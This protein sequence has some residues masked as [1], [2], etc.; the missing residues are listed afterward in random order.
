MLFFE[1]LNKDEK[2]IAVEKGVHAQDET[3]CVGLIPAAGKGMRAYPSTAKRPKP[4]FEF[5]PLS[6]IER[7]IEMMRDKVG[8]TTIYIIVGY[9][10]EMILQKLGTGER[11]GVTIRYILCEDVD[12]GLARGI[13]LAK[14]Y[15]SSPFMTILGDEL[16]MNTNH[17]KL[18]G[19]L[20][21]DCDVV[22][23]VKITNNRELIRQNY[24]VSLDEKGNITQLIEKPSHPKNNFLGCGTFIFK[25]SIF[26]Y[27]ERTFPSPATDRIELIDV[28]NLMAKDGLRVSAFEITGAYH[29]INR[30]HDIQ[31]ALKTYRKE[32]FK[33]QTVSLVIPA[34]N[35][36]D[37]IGYV[38]DN[39]LRANVAVDEIVVADN[40]ST[41]KTAEIARKK[42]A[43]VLS[44]PLSGYGDALKYGMDN[45]IGDILILSEADGS[46]DAS[47]IPKILEYLKDVDMV[48]GSRTTKEMIEQGANMKCILRWGNI[49]VA[50][51][52]QLLWIYDEPR[53]TDVGCT[54]RGI[55]RETYLEI[56]DNLTSVGPAFSPEMMVELLRARRKI[57]EI[58]V[59]YKARIGGESKH[60]GNFLHIMRTGLSMVAVILKKRFACL[61]GGCG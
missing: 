13:L 52:M 3:L 55:W 32:K 49:F 20:M 16:Y 30:V 50:K 61:F 36:E 12:M 28:I 43:K 11:F 56:R 45:A 14:D 54:Y 34:Y 37:S 24:S 25:P 46:F 18:H 9:H 27:I 2:S 38:I 6:I 48:V 7:N 10:G 59:S 1:P 26:S 51:C 22:C 39:V 33:K 15:I 31:A 21:G 44:K 41:D 19:R 23:G 47:D 5:G 17:D 60:S 29:N 35:E 40:C 58:P 8:I 42:G 53:F 4:L 57:I